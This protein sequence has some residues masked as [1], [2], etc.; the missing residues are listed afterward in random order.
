MKATSPSSSSP[1]W[2]VVRQAKGKGLTSS[3][4]FT[5]DGTLIEAWAS[6]KS[7]QPIDAAS[8]VLTQ[9]EGSNDEPPPPDDPGNPTVVFKGQKRSNATHRSKTDPDA[10]LYKKSTGS[11]SE[12]AYLGHVLM[13]NLN[14]L[15]VDCRLTLLHGRAEYEAALDIVADVAGPGVTVGADKAYDT[16]EFIHTLLAR[17]VAPHVA[18]HATRHGGS[19]VPA[20]YDQDAGYQVSQRKRKLVE[21]GF[22]WMK[23]VAM[24]RQ[25][26]YRGRLKVDWVFTFAAAAYNLVKMK[27]LLP[28]AS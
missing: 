15:L 11:P 7:F 4:H 25:V 28:C 12:L 10:R 22:G 5:V 1:T 26:K 13:E 20:C 18:R 27:K 23:T 3:E 9:E 6:H 19:A 16:R 2:S 21:E 8:P 17:D 14:G 24:I